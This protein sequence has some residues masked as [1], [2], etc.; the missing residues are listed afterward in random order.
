MHNKAYIS[1]LSPSW[2]EE[3]QQEVL[4]NGIPTWP[5]IPLY[6]D[7]L[8]PRALRDRDTDRLAGR[9]ALAR[10]TSRRDRPVIHVASL[11]VLDF[12]V[13]GFRDFLAILAQQRA[14]LVAHAEGESYDLTVAGEAGRAAQRFPISRTR[15]GRDNWLALGTAVSAARRRAATDEAIKAIEDR[16]GKKG[17][18]QKALVAETGLSL[19]TVVDRLGLW[20]D[21]KEKIKRAAKRKAQREKEKQNDPAHCG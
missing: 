3:R 2:P 14:I 4:A 11:A 7:E 12:R 19:N 8:G 9:Q 13:A 5:V 15:V 10:V 21:A 17:Q 20:R 1:N 18:R 16:W 6:R